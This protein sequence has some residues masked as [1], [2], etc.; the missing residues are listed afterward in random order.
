[1][2]AQSIEDDTRKDRYAEFRCNGFERSWA[3]PE[4]AKKDSVTANYNAGILTVE[5]PTGEEREKV[6][7]ID[8]M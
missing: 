7:K 4:S 2:T 3:L 6:I 8:V 5:I 1:V